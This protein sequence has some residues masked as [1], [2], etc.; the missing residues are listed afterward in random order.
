MWKHGVQSGSSSAPFGFTLAE[1]L[2]ALALAGIVMT[3]I[4]TVVRMHKDTY[5]RGTTRTEAVQKAR[6][7]VDY[8]ERELRLAGAGTRR[9]QPHIVYADAD[10][11]VFNADLV[12][13]DPDD[14]VAVYFD[15]DAPPSESVGPDSAGMRLPNGDRYPRI[16]YGPNRT[17]GGAE[18][19][20]LRFVR[21]TDSRYAFI[22]QVNESEADTLV[23]GLERPESGFLSYFALDQAGQY[24]RLPM[25]LIHEEPVHGGPGDTARSART[26]SIR[27]IRASFTVAVRG[28]DGVDTRLEMR[29]AVDPRNA[30]LALH[31]SC[32]DQ[33]IV[34]ATPSLSL[35]ADPAV[36]VEWD[37]AFDERGGE[38]D[39]RQYNLYRAESGAGPWLPLQTIPIASVNRYR[40]KDPSVEPG[41]TYWYAV[42]ATDCTPAESDWAIA[43]PIAVPPDG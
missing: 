30:G 2:I 8:L 17:P 25:P 40:Y 33:P 6:Y 4:V 11:V 7:A 43:G 32:G 35:Q 5:V 42:A 34:P 26:D 28:P 39:V 1:L 9:G 24:R 13:R 31:A 18:T 19:L 16:W 14:A 10:A 3:G 29:T 15:P 20:T 37:P 36:Q 23:T 22:R 27:S 38:S 12:T 21:G 41:K